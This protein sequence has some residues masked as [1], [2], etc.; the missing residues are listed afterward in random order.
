M[1]QEIFKSD[2]VNDGWD[3]QLKGKAVPVGV[4]V[5][6]VTYELYGNESQEGERFE[7][8]GTFVLVQ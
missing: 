1:G 5:Y 2:D 7:L 3:G 6:A 8:Q 4:Y